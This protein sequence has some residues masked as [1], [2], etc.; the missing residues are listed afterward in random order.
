[1][2]VVMGDVIFYVKKHGE[3]CPAGLQ[4]QIQMDPRNS[5]LILIR[6]KKNYKLNKKLSYYSLF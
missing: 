2:Y 3:V 6:I 1:M 5:F 4:S